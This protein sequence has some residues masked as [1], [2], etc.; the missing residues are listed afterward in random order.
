VFPNPN[1]ALLPGMFVR[2]TI[3]EMGIQQ[4][5]IV[6]QKAVSIETDGSKAVWIIDTS[7]I[8]RKRAVV[9]STTYKNNWVIKSGLEVGDAVVVEGAMMLKEGVKVVPKSIKSN[10]PKITSSGATN[11]DEPTSDAVENNKTSSN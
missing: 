11:A 9:T 3:E 2:A 8:A 6:P 5:I 4:T 1:A 10:D 7:N